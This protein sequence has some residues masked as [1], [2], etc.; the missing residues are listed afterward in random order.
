MRGVKMKISQTIYINTDEILKSIGDDSEKDEKVIIAYQVALLM[1]MH[2][3]NPF[4]KVENSE[5]VI[6]DSIE[7]LESGKTKVK[8]HINTQS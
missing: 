6:I 1:K 8:G 2:N 7:K 3:I 5:K 4:I